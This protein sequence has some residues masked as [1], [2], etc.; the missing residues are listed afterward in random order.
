MRSGTERGSAVLD[1]LLVT[2][3]LVAV[4]LS[5]VQLAAWAARRATAQ[6]AAFTGARAGARTPGTTVQRTE[7]A[8]RSAQAALPSDAALPRARVTSI[9]GI[10][11][12]QV[13]VPVPLHL[14]AW[15]VAVGPASSHM[16][17]E[18]R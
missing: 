7:V 6:D 11:V 2:P 17:I 3:L 16:A 18:P 14:L 12:V 15:P 8:E 5:V 1:F 13:D 9:A 10:A 4:L